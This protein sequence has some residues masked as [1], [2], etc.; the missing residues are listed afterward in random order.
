M[1]K[2]HIAS[3]QQIPKPK[4]VKQLMSFL[5][6]CSYCRFF[7][8]HFSETEKPLRALCYGPGKTSSSPV[9]WTPETEKAFVTPAYWKCLM[10]LS[11]DV[12]LLIHLLCLLCQ[13]MV[14][15]QLCS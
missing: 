3:I 6:M 11:K 12:T 15:P 4:T 10:S 7:V 13:K 5:G 1:S 8:P 2:K 14:S 9:D